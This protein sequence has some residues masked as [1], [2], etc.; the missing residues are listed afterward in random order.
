MLPTTACD[1]LEKERKGKE[2][3]GK[4]QVCSK[5]SLKGKIFFSHFSSEVV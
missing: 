1:S 4:E 5:V 3:K 2:T